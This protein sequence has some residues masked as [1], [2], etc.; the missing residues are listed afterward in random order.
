MQRVRRDIYSGVVLE[1]IVY[2][3]R[4]S[5]DLRLTRNGRGLTL[6]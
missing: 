3:A 2:T 5:R 4:G 6:R 1:R